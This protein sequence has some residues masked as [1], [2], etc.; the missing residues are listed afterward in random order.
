MTGAANSAARAPGGPETALDAIIVGAGIAG[1]SAALILGRAR[2]RTLMFDDARQSNRASHAVHNLIGHDGRA[3][4]ELYRMAASQLAAY[5]TVRTLLARA[6]RAERQ[7]T[8]F[9]ITDAS[10]ATH[11]ARKL[12][13]AGGLAYALPA[14]PGL[15]ELWGTTALGCPYCHGFEFA[16]RR[17]AVLG[18]DAGALHQAVLLGDWSADVVLCAD[19]PADLDADQRAL[20]TEADVRVLEQPVTRLAARDGRL[21]AVEFAD[22]SALARDAVF[23]RP[24]LRA[25]DELATQLGA[26]HGDSGG[27]IE[28]DEYNRASIPGVWAAGDAAAKIGQ[29]AMAAASG[30]NAGIWVHQTLV[31]EERGLP[32]PWTTASPP[33][34]L[35]RATTD[36]H[37]LYD[38][39]QFE[40]PT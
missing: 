24:T 11:H 1:L 22:G 12:I 36:A 5:P 6:E 35:A 7:G 40:Y 23:V 38:T 31:S 30:V 4:D 3:P 19:G 14:T 28:V 34:E 29:T 27:T 32:L 33:H 26:R 25:R 10:G 2:R 39:T 37:L 8:S 18:G 17:L 16:D 13:L 9:A 20:L 15:A 21:A